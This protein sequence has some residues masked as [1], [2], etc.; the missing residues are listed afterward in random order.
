[1]GKRVWGPAA[2]N[3]SLASRPFLQVGWTP[4]ITGWFRPWMAPRRSCVYGY[5]HQVLCRVG[6]AAR[7]TGCMPALPKWRAAAQRQQRNRA[8]CGQ[9]L[10]RRG[11]AL[12]EGR[13][14]DGIQLTLTGLKDAAD[15][16]ETAAAHSNLCGG[17]ALLR[18]WAEALEHCNT[19]ISLDPTNWHSY[20]N[21]AAVF[22][23]RGQYALALADLRFGL[24][25]APQS[26]TLLKSLSVVEHNQKVI[27]K[28]DSATLR[29]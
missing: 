27:N 4:A 22:A 16:L 21:R 9:H 11:R 18:Q 28:R 1:M 10:V 15:P 6:A 2:A 17:Y 7:G 23:A 24:E 13:A 29:S 12:E 5:L 20:N 19:A 25:L 14:A 26:G 3:S 8:Q